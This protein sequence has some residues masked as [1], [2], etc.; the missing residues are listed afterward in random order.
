[1][2]DFNT[3]AGA[4]ADSCLGRTCLEWMADGE[5]AALDRLLVLERLALEDPELSALSA[6]A[7][8]PLPAGAAG[9]ASSP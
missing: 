8:E 9:R 5:L 7:R 3:N 1:M 2:G 4:S 6:P